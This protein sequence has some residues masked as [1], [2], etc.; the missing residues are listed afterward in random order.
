M[1]AAAQLLSPCPDH[2]H[3]T[4]L[5]DWLNAFNLSFLEAKFIINGYSDLRRVAQLQPWDIELLTVNAHMTSHDPIRIND[6]P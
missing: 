3:H 1:V 2:S 4:S 5:S 6:I